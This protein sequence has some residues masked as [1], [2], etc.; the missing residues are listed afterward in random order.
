LL[1]DAVGSIG[2]G[3]FGAG[4]TKAR[5]NEKC[6]ERSKNREVISARIGGGKKECEGSSTSCIEVVE[7]VVVQPV[8]LKSDVTNGVGG[9][10][11]GTG[12]ILAENE[13]GVRGEHSARARPGGENGGGGGGGHAFGE[14]DES[15]A[16]GFTNGSVGSE[17]ACLGNKVREDLEGVKRLVGWLWEESG[18]VA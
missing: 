1:D 5:Q 2:I 15:M 11:E 12:E 17:E 7:W 14:V 10:V 9:R 3:F 8:A 6:D 18:C 13:R 4:G 16:N